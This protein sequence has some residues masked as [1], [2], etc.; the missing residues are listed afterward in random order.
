[1]TPAFHSKVN[2]EGLHAAM[3][4]EHALE[5][6]RASSESPNNI[7]TAF[8]FPQ[9]SPRSFSLWIMLFLRLKSANFTSKKFDIYSQVSQL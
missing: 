2:G 5:C 6:G 8:V 4:A 3:A 7:K 1:M 9:I